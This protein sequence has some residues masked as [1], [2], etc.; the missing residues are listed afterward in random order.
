[1][2]LAH[3]ILNDE[4][5]LP[6]PDTKVAI[7]SGN[8]P[9]AELVNEKHALENRADGRGSIRLASYRNF[10]THFS[11]VSRTMYLPIS[12]ERPLEAQSHGARA[13]GFGFIYSHHMISRIRARVLATPQVTFTGWAAL[14]I[15]GLPYWVNDMPLQVTTPH[16]G[17]TPRS[18]FDSFHVCENVSYA[19]A[20]RDHWCSE[21]TNLPDESE[22]VAGGVALTR[23]LRDVLGDRARWWL[24]QR[25]WLQDFS[26]LSAADL[27]AV[28]LLDATQR[29]LALNPIA[30]LRDSSTLTSEK[31]LAAMQIDQRK[32][33]KLLRLSLP[34][35][36]SPI[37]TLLRI[38]VQKI[39][40]DVKPQVEL[41]DADTVDNPFFDEMPLTTADLWSRSAQI[42]IFYDGWHHASSGQRHI[43]VRIDRILQARG[44]HVLRFTSMDLRELAHIV[45]SVERAVDSRRSG[46]RLPLFE[47]AAPVVRG[48]SFCCSGA[49]SGGGA[50][51]HPPVGAATGWGTPPCLPG[52]PAVAL[53]PG[54]RDL[55]P[56]SYTSGG[57]KPLEF[58]SKSCI[59]CRG[60]ATL[61]R[62]GSKSAGGAIRMRAPHPPPGSSA[63][64][65][66]LFCRLR[67]FLGCNQPCW[68]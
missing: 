63:A 37:E 56:N 21:F 49:S 51:S 6:W 65:S 22:C 12:M 31:A 38:V 11:K 26:G 29:F 66:P 35:A 9:L 19:L 68:G 57:G 45:N 7:L 46:R 15:L 1:M 28:Q 48:G 59:G 14:R 8:H 60:G 47:V 17:R 62:R 20:S 10:K 30:D 50:S 23:A 58:G 36:D 53:Q 5:T 44:V 40:P 16:G 32:L 43:D 13:N 55:L 3:I 34:L 39:L 64:I 42:A 2:N 41:W 25:T 27:R 67:R 18:A 24:P 54:M 52:T 4:L 61:T 33:R